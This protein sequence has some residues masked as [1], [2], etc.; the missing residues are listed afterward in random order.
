MNKIVRSGLKLD[1]HIHSC[2]SSN[3]DGRKVRNNT[4]ENLPILVQK[5]NENGVNICSITDHDMF[6]FEMYSELK[7]FENSDNSIEKVFPGVEFSVNFRTQNDCKTIHVIAIF[8]DEQK[9]KIENIEKVLQNKR[10]NEGNTY[11]EQEF[12]NVLREIDIDTILI[13][14]QKK[15]LS[16]TSTKGNDA[17]SLGT[18]KF[19]EFLYSDYFE[20]F[21]YKN[22]RNEVFNKNFLIDNEVKKDITF[23]TG[24]DCHDWNC[25]PQEGPN[26]TAQDFPYT[27]AKCLPS[28]KGLVMA[29]TDHTRLKTVNSFFSA[30]DKIYNE[31]V[32]EN[33]GNKTSVP[34]SKGI[35]VI[36]GDNSIGKSALLHAI[37]NY[38]KLS[39]SSSLCKGYKKYLK[40]ESIK[41]K[42]KITDDMLFCFDMQGEVRSKFEENKLNADDFFKDY[43]PQAIDT[44]QYETIIISEINKLEKY[45]NE[46]FSI[47]RKIA[48]LSRFKIEI[49]DGNPESL[50]FSN[51]LR[52]SK[53]T[54]KDLEEIEG[55]FNDVINKIKELYG[56]KLDDIDIQYIKDVVAKL[57]TINSKYVA[58]KESI[59]NENN[60]KEKIA[61]IVEN[62]DK[63]HKRTISNNA[64]RSDTFNNNTENLQQELI[65]ILKAKRELV[66]FSPNI[67]E[68]EIT[69]KTNKVFNYEFVS[70][71][72]IEKINNDYITELINGILKNDVSLDLENIT[73]KELFNYI[74]YIGDS[75]NAVETLIDRIKEQVKNDLS[76]KNSIIVDGIDKYTELSSGFNSKIYFDLISHETIKNGIYIIDQPEDNVSQTSISEYLIG[77]FKEMSEN[78]QIIMVTH[79]P[80]FIV[81]LDIDNLIFIS[82][83]QDGLKLQ[84][85]A[86]EYSCDEYS[87]LDI[88]AKN[89][90]GGLDSIRKRWKRYEKTTNLY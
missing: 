69:P 64:K 20:A 71:T 4:K 30:S 5:L 44:R 6:S 72:H 27:Y 3:K 15:S 32:I 31:L 79:N 39:S 62:F 13:A 77:Y 59:V 2:I 90:D 35:N 76:Q 37:T 16:S 7:K 48:N 46:K 85:G 21:E 42:S 24:T 82:K 38:N 1:M 83:D 34:F 81:N 80:Q 22:K 28:F 43:F 51:N 53:K 60:R 75:N 56:L 23:V 61:T 25:Y 29:I 17:N 66:P 50:H 65:D 78:H 10:P 57:S 88:V 18:E 54:T 87:I 49:V 40:D 9:D 86:L 33:N 14:H 70:K 55:S 11:S 19:Y 52:K 26:D 47:D 67:E 36:I 68:I 45:L 8:S 89:I 84:S 58:R 63:E 74:R 73:E 12:L 41:I